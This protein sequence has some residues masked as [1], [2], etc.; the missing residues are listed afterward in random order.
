MDVGDPTVNY[1]STYTRVEDSVTCVSCKKAIPYFPDA[2]PS[3]WIQRS[4]P[5]RVKPVSKVVL[6][7]RVW[8]TVDVLQ[9]IL[10]CLLEDLCKEFR[11]NSLE[12]R[13]RMGM[14]VTCQ[15]G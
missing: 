3:D 13:I 8:I 12:P 6:L 5:H 15:P 2:R 10:A 11:R 7:G 14:Y 9:I 4:N 1:V